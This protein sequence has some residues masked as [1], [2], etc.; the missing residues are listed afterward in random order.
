[1]ETSARSSRT[2]FVESHTILGQREF[3]RSQYLRC[4]RRH[5]EAQGQYRRLLPLLLQRCSPRQVTLNHT[6]EIRVRWP[7]EL[8]LSER[9]PATGFATL[10]CLAI[11]LWLGQTLRRCCGRTRHGDCRRPRRSRQFCVTALSCDPSVAAIKFP[12]LWTPQ[13][14]FWYPA[15]MA[16]LAVSGQR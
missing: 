9:N 6:L 13:R 4:C 11:S 5:L 16:S 3:R 1:M 7:N 2:Q 15:R 12:E 10:S 8:A 14:C